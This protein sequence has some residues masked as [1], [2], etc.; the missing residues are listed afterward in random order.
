PKGLHGVALSP[1]GR[2]LFA[3]GKDSSIREFDLDSGEEKVLHPGPTPAFVFASFSAD[4]RYLAVRTTA[5]L[6][7]MYHLAPL[8][9]CST[10]G[11]SQLYPTGAALSRDGQRLLMGTARKGNNPDGDCPALLFDAFSGQL[12]GHTPPQHKSVMAVALSGDGDYAL[13]TDMQTWQR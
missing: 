7:Q 9:R 1:D 4:G 2:K 13:T 10:F 8:Q 12:I 5:Q 3:C 11:H 6:M